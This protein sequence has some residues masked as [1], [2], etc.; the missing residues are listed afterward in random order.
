M[1]EEEMKIWEEW[2]N[3][4]NEKIDD[5]ERIIKN[6]G[7]QEI[8]DVKEAEV[9]AYLSP[10]KWFMAFSEEDEKIKECVDKIMLMDD[11]DV[12]ERLAPVVHLYLKSLI[13]I[14]KYELLN[15]SR[16]EKI[17]DNEKGEEGRQRDL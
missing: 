7:N 4:A 10:I 2:I 9:I 1:D 16:I 11:V 3:N 8:L 12:D 13:T 6:S 14:H 17:I 15:L 5:Y